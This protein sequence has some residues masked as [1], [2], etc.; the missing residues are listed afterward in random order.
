MPRHY[1]ACFKDRLMDTQKDAPPP[2]QQPMIYI[3]GASTDHLPQPH[4]G[5]IIRYRLL[6]KGSNWFSVFVSEGIT[7]FFRYSKVL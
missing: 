6:F 1:K 7:V 4:V 2:K 5:G 3:C